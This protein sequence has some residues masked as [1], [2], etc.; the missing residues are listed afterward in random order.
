MPGN[1][2][3]YTYQWYTTVPIVGA[4]SPSI[5]GLAGG[6]YSVKVVETST[7]CPNTAKV[8]ILNDTPPITLGT[9]DATAS[10][11][12]IPANGRIE[13]TMSRARLELHVQLDQ[14]NLRAYCYR[15]RTTL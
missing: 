5:T 4:K 11:T 9:I 7:G 8:T 10:T 3:D 1:T 6:T 2:A 15:Y 13:V 14:R 12:C